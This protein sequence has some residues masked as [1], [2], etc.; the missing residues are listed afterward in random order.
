M[1]ACSYMVLVGSNVV[2]KKAGQ[3]VR[4]SCSQPGSVGRGAEFGTTE[5]KGVGWEGGGMLWFAWALQIH[6]TYN[7]KAD[8]LDVD[9][10]VG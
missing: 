9:F 10:F 5:T 7:K 4:G 2:R 3:E 6:Q 1:S 8:I